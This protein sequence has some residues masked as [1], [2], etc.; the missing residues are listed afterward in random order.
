M[1]VACQLGCPG[2]RLGQPPRH[3]GPGLGSPQAPLPSLPGAIELGP[4]GVHSGAVQ[5]RQFKFRKAILATRIDLLVP[6][7][8][9]PP[10]KGSRRAPH[11]DVLLL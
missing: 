1:L 5:Q 3:M 2:I 8:H 4:R 11:W 7:R 10:F 9:G 6:K